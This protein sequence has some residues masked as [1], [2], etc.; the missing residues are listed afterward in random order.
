MAGKPL[1]GFI[2]Q[3]FIGKNYADDFER[4]GYTTVRYALEEPYVRNREKIKD[5]EFVLIAVPTP[6][7]PGGFDYSIVR[8]AIELVGKGKA[9]VIKSTIVPG[10]TKQLQQEF[11]DKTVIYSPEFL[12]EAT[13]AHDAAHPFMNIVGLTEDTPRQKAV[14]E[15]LH[16]ALPPAPFSQ[17]CTS[18]EAE[19]IKY[20]HNGSGYTQI[21]FFNLMFDLAMRHGANWHMIQ[22]AIEA[23]P[24]V[25]NRYARPIHKSG[26]GAGGHCFIKDV[27]ALRAEYAEM[28]GDEAGTALFEA[29]E[30]KNIEL[31][32]GTGK[33]LDLLEGV[34][35]SAVLK[36][37]YEK[38]EMPHIS[39]LRGE[40]KVLVCTEA[41]DRSDPLLGYFHGWVKEFARHAH[42]VHV[43]CLGYGERNLPPNV[44]EHSLGKESMRKGNRF[45]KRFIYSG[46]FIRRIVKSRKEYDSVLVHLSSE[47]TILGAWIWKLLGKRIGFWHNDAKATLF[48]RAAI[49]LSDVVF[50]SNPDSYAARYAH[51]RY[52]PMGVDADMY[53]LE[54]S[55]QKE[56]LLFLGRIHPSKKLEAIMEAFGDIRKNVKH[57]TLDMYG[58]PRP[59][60]EQ[61]AAKL[62]SQF[63]GLEREGALTYR[64]TV[65]HERTPAVYAKHEIFVHAG[66]AHGSKKTLYEAMAA[67]CIVITSE[68]EVKDVIDSR[69]F[70]EEVNAETLGKAIRAA[71]ALSEEKREHARSVARAYVRR[72][73]ALSSVVPTLLEMLT[74][75]EGELSHY[76]KK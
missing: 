46:R 32:R 64:G 67:G 42:K 7:T 38:I 9:A 37:P 47:F 43:I 71:L 3:G 75:S 27:A 70:L 4:R 48:S 15:R 19:I 40:V 2:G 44:T 54:R 50:Y 20:T 28:V 18:T 29:M 5:C 63:S 73:H 76:L 39:S 52:V 6:T 69:L 72:E 33:D 35:G 58:E 55:A 62:R 26:R 57:L 36:E 34:Y 53:T 56:S 41:I 14:A 30:R 65:L 45:L 31:L 21:M 8:A 17:T 66:S 59:G 1:I 11:P 61:Y 60:D 23:D 68:K 24:L 51:A 25:N 10:T 13:A 49:A 22:R 74:R 12:S 16:A